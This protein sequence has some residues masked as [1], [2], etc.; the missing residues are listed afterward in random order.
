MT[1]IPRISTWN[2]LSLNSVHISNINS[3]DTR[4]VCVILVIWFLIFN[5]PGTSL[6][7]SVIVSLLFA[8]ISDITVMT[9]IHVQIANMKPFPGL[10]LTITKNFYC[11]I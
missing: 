7:Y 4:H 2:I 9:K 10:Q 11:K 5:L 6:Y 1:N 3:Y 8:N